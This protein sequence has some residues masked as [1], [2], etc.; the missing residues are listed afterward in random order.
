MLAIMIILSVLI[1]FGA[2]ALCAASSRYHDE[3]EDNDVEQED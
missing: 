3:Y 2:W 1:G